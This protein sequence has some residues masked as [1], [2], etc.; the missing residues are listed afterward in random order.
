MA[1]RKDIV[2]LA[3]LVDE[4]GATAL[5]EDVVKEM[6]A[7]GYDP[8]EINQ[9]AIRF[10]RANIN[11]RDNPAYFKELNILSG[12]RPSEKS[13]VAVLSPAEELA[14]EREGC[15]TMLEFIFGK[16]PDEDEEE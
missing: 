10:Y 7:G 5:D 4:M 1:K 12:E 14:K 16:Q 8:T 6:I 15:K 3:K 2:T 9:Q 11:A 13:A